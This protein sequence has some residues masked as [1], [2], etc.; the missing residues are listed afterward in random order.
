MIDHDVANR[1]TP[2]RIIAISCIDRT[3][4]KPHMANDD[5]VTLELHGVPCN[6]HTVTGAVLPA[7]GYTELE[8]E[9]DPSSE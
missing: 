2:D 9:C 3:P 5:I 7:M 4:S 8:Y 6:T 1:I